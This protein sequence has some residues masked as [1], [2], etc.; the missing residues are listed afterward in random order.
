[1]NY[2]VSCLVRK[3]QTT[4][5]MVP[6]RSVTKAM[7]TFLTIYFAE[8][9][10]DEADGAPIGFTNRQFLYRYGPTGK[11]N[12]E[13]CSLILHDAANHVMRGQYDCA[14]ILARLH[15]NCHCWVQAGKPPVPF[16]KGAN[17]GFEDGK[18][19]DW[20]T[21]ISR[22]MNTVESETPVEVTTYIDEHL[23]CNCLSK[24]KKA[25]QKEVNDHTSCHFCTKAA[26]A[27]ALKE[28]SKCHAA[29]YCSKECQVH[30]ICRSHVLLY[31]LLACL[32][33]LDSLSLL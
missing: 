17:A 11:I 8:R 13:L 12:Q 16:G 30:R 9:A 27:S 5:T 29:F 18:L 14:R 3:P 7:V 4:V 19:P 22:L 23:P 25:A 10:K 2:K 28:C 33:A 6:R 21:E 24:S 32:L 31:K 15:M 20:I 26:S 1:M